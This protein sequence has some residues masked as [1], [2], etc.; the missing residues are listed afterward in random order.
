L[1]TS[2]FVRDPSNLIVL[3]QPEA[4]EGVGGNRTGEGVKAG[5][6]GMWIETSTRG[7]SMAETAG[8]N[9]EEDV[10]VPAE[11]LA[12]NAATAPEV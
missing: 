1:F 6:D 12:T 8:D 10:N 4:D 7:T 11:T 2:I 5:G 9:T 3:L